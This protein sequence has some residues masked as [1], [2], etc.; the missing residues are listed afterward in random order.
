VRQSDR[1]ST[2]DSDP[3]GLFFDP[4][5]DD[6]FLDDPEEDGQPTRVRRV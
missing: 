6:S 5:D 2:T 4:S 1:E 3:H